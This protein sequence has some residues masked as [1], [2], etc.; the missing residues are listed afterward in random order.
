MLG[1]RD[2]VAGADGVVSRC[3]TELMISFEGEG[4]VCQCW[5]ERDGV[6]EGAW[7]G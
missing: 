6:R 1:G 2:M 5:S 4:H 3:L 7:F